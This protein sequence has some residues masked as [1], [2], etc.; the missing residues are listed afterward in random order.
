LRE[1]GW[2]SKANKSSKRIAWYIT[3]IVV[4]IGILIVTEEAEKPV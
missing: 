4:L 1:N 2:R 3:Q